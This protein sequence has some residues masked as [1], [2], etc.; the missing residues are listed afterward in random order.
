MGE[1]GGGTPRRL[2]SEPLIAN[3]REFYAKYGKVSR[4]ADE[5]SEGAEVNQ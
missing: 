3:R 5:G 2:Y 1:R 4:D